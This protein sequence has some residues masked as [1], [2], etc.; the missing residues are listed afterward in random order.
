MSYTTCFDAWKN[1]S[2]ILSGFLVGKLLDKRDV[3]VKAILSF[4]E[5]DKVLRNEM[6]GSIIPQT[7]SIL[8]IVYFVKVVHGVLVSIYDIGY[9]Q[10]LGKSYMNAM[11]SSIMMT[12]VIFSLSF[13]EF[14]GE[15]VSAQT[16]VT[17]AAFCLIGMIVTPLVV[18]FSF[19]LF[20]NSFRSGVYS[21]KDGSW[22]GGIARMFKRDKDFGD[23]LKAWFLQDILSVVIIMCWVVGIV[24]CA[25]NEAK[26][27]ITLLMFVLLT[28]INSVFDYAVNRG[29]FFDFVGKR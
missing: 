23:V 24:T 11:L 13:V 21:A 28:V 9:L 12:T 17:A 25:S 14:F 22:Y 6:V 15:L 4:C 5:F 3:I 8:V 1:F 20:H 26:I 27:K 10:R 29:Y 19:D 7:M 2:L 18:F 16:T